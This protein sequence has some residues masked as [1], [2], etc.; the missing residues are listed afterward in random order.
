MSAMLNQKE[1]RQQKFDHFKKQALLVLT[2]ALRA[3]LMLAM[4]CG[5]VNVKGKKLELHDHGGS[6]TVR[7]GYAVVAYDQKKHG[8]IVGLIEEKQRVPDTPDST[9]G[10]APIHVHKGTSSSGSYEFEYQ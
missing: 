1:V 7:D 9:D 4:G 6:Y 3:P 5:S 10:R 8:A 2:T